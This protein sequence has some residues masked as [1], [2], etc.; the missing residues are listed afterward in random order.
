MYDHRA[1]DGEC[2]HMSNTLRRL[3]RY[4]PATAS[5]ELLDHRGG[6]YEAADEAVD[7]GEM[8]GAVP[9]D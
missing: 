8:L 5:Q 3:L 2:D 6:K 1:K 4:D 7:E 9:E